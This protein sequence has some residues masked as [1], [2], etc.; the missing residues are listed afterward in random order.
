[1]Q[2]NILHFAYVALFF[3]A[4]FTSCKKAEVT[5]SA[6]DPQLAFAVQIDQSL[7]TF[8]PAGNT[9]AKSSFLWTEGI[10]NISQF[11]LDAKRG[12][13]AST[14]TTGALSNI[15]LFGLNQAVS[16][17]SIPKGDYTDAKATVVY[18]QTTSAPYPLTLK[19]TFTTAGG[20]VIPVQFELNDNLEVKISV[21]NIIADGTKNFTTNIWMHL[22]ILLNGINPQ[23]LD[24]AARVN[25]LILINKT[26]NVGLYAKMKGNIGGCAGAV[27][28]STVK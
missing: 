3:S 18:S 28:S 11:R 7:F 2:K 12:G 1:M 8:A 16:N 21:S 26:N 5:V 6:T 24:S 25:G 22:N 27:L 20:I 23:D 19:G 17:T 9:T 4:M 10:A 14:Y 13:T 15:N